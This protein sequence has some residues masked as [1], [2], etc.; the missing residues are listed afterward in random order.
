MAWEGDLLKL[1]FIALEDLNTDGHVGVAIQYDTGKVAALPNKVTGILLPI[2]KPKNNEMGSIGV[3]GVMK[4]RA[5]GTV[6]A[7]AHITSTTSGYFTSLAGVTSGG[8]VLGKC[9]EAA[10]SGGLGVGLFSFS[11]VNWC[12]SSLG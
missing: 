1:N 10:A 5:G 2:S 7:G 6:A 4:F 9:L 3:S 12:A 11:H 8:I